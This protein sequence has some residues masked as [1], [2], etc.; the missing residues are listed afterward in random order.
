M[1]QM[2]SNSPTSGRTIA[3]AVAKIPPAIIVAAAALGAYQAAPMLVD[4]FGLNRPPYMSADIRPLAPP[5]KKPVVTPAPEPVTEP[6]QKQ[7][8]PPVA[9]PVMQQEEATVAPP[10]A[11]LEPPKVAA[12]PAPARPVM[13]PA[14]HGQSFRVRPPRLQLSH[15]LSGFRGMVHLGHVTQMLHFVRRFHR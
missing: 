2:Y 13:S 10:V 14:M 11:I 1:T 15:G 8:A 12:L 9:P 7:V 5:M 4:Y 3:V 6:V